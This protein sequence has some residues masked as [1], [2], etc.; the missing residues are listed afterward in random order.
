M[1]NFRIISVGKS[2]ESWIRSGFEH[3]SKLISRYARLEENTIKAEKVLDESRKD[4]F[5]QKE[6]ERILNRLGNAAPVV[7]LDQAGKLMSSEKLS[8]YL[9][10]HFKSGNNSIDFVIGSALGLA[11]EV[12]ARADLLLAF[13]KMTFPHEL[14]RLMLAE[15]LYRAMS[16]LH[17]GK[18][19]K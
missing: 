5:L 7:V 2:K 13:S 11:E 10:K 1:V 14:A 18:Y 19:H 15:Q 4:I 6:G 16:I 12:K 8:Q 9:N 3:Y 17:G